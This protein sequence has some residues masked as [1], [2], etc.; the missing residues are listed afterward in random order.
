MRPDR[1]VLCIMAMAQTVAGHG[2]TVGLQ[3]LLF[4]AFGLQPALGQSLR[5]GLLFAALS[6]LRVRGVRPR[7]G[8]FR[9]R[10]A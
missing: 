5:L 1:P 4:P 2:L 10:L 6:L 9:P 7:R 8:P 3:L